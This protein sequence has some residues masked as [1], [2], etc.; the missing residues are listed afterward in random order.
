VP[1]GP[2]PELALGQTDRVLVST[3]LAEAAGLGLLLSV[4]RAGAALVLVPDPTAVDLVQ[5]ARDEGVTATYGLVVAGL[6]RLSPG[7]APS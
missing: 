1:L 7:G 2:L 3:G 6:P 5:V 4:L